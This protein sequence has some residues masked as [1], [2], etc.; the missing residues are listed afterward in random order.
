MLSRQEIETAR[1][2]HYTSHAVIR[3]ELR[4]LREE[5]LA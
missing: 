2:S 4:F 5:A 1:A 3:T